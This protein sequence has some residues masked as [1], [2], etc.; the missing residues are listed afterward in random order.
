LIWAA[1]QGFEDPV[2]ILLRHGANPAIRDDRQMTAADWAREEGVFPHSGS[3]NRVVT[4]DRRKKQ[5]GLATT[6][7]N[8][9]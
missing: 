9:A 8:T 4:N 2:E 6:R 7:P 5:G 1:K 3:S